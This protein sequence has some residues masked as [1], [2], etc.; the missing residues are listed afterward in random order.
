MVEVEVL[1]NNFKD[2][3]VFPV[4]TKVVRNGVE[5]LLQNELLQKGD[6]YSI[7][8]ERYTK[9]SKLGYVTKAKKDK[10]KAD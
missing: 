6:T 8:K 3:E 4:E 2:L 5:I 10:E 9:L 7:T 1:I